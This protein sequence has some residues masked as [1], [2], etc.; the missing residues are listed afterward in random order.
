MNSLFRQSKF[1]KAERESFDA[2]YILEKYKDFIFGETD[3][4][5]VHLS[6][7]LTTDSNKYYKSETV[8]TLSFD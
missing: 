3:L 4:K 1:G 7:R 5:D 8:V 6:I 2:T